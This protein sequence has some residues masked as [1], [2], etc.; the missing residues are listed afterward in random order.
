MQIMKKNYI[1]LLMI[2]LLSLLVL[3]SITSVSGYAGRYIYPLDDTYIHLSMAKNFAQF[4]TWGITQYEFSSTTSSPFF[5]FLLSVFIKIFGTWDYIP[6]VINTIAG[7][8]ILIIC[9]QYLRRF[10]TLSQVIILLAIILLMPM[11]LMIIV[12]MEHVFHALTMLLTF[13][14]FEKYI[15]V[16]S[17]KNFSLL[18]LYALLATGFRYESL[19]FILIMCMFL[20]FIKKDFAKSILLGIFALLPVIIYGWISVEKGSYFL[21]NSLVLKGNTNDGIQ[22]FIMR[23]AGNGYRGLSVLM[24][25]IIVLTQLFWNIKNE[26][27]FINKLTK[28]ALPVVVLA[29]FGLHLMFANFGWLIRYE[30]Y[31]IV[32]LLFVIAPFFNEIFS[33]SKPKIILRSLVV[34]LLVC[35]LWMRFVNML[36]Y[37][38][39][40]SKNIYDQQ[41]QLAD[42]LH[43]YYRD[44]WIVANDIGA[45]TY[46]NNIHLLD[47]YGLGNIEIAKLRKDD[48]AKFKDNKPLQ[49]YIADVTKNGEYKVAIVFEDWVKMPDFYTKVGA[50]TLHDNYM[51]GGSTV[52]F[53]AIKE[54]QVAIL[55]NQLKEFSQ[56]VPKD[57]TITIV[58]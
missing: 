9:N 7:L 4:G 40:A 16:K 12:G 5:T 57:V 26:K 10:S 46:Y 36:K 13:I 20:F 56:K 33:Y 38:T 25:V 1:L 34:I 8:L 6:I 19:F 45:I 54:E 29:G 58:N 55:K 3:Y 30:A 15:N 31:M 27:G 48:H 44:S 47:T 11:H 24:L 49:K 23:V 42:F 2:L 53:F 28:K 22:G 18:V 17:N 39:L 50:L 14:Y 21:P 35:T 32:L 41:I 51:N 37:Q 52:S 43:Q